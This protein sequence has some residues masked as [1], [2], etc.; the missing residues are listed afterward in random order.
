[1]FKIKNLKTYLITH[2][3]VIYKVYNNTLE[4]VHNHESQNVFNNRF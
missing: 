1:M 3:D 4:K 2:F